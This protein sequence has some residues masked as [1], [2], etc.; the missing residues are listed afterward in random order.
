MSEAVSDSVGARPVKKWQRRSKAAWRALIARQAISGETIEAFCRAQ[1]VRR[2]TFERWRGLLSPAT[3][4]PDVSPHSV[5]HHNDRLV[6]SERSAEHRFIDASTRTKA[7]RWHCRDAPG[8]P[9]QCN[10]R[11]RWCQKTD[12]VWPGWGRSCAS[13]RRQ[14]WPLMSARLLRAV[15][16]GS[17]SAL[18]ALPA[19]GV[20]GQ[21][22]THLG[23]DR[24]A[25]LDDTPPVLASHGFVDGNGQMGNGA[26]KPT[27]TCYT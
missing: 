21:K 9:R 17:R 16:R 15:S 25:L 13:S 2:S 1:G 5:A 7:L 19:L 18:L 20:T 10:R 3:T 11:G 24:G 12:H 26:L 14:V 8:R 4:T 23:T 22:L 27:N 6:A